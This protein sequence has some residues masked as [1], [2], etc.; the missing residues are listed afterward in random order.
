VVSVE[1]LHVYIED[2]LTS[3][4][5]CD[6]DHVSVEWESVSHETTREGILEMEVTTQLRV[7]NVCSSPP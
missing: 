4:S 5:V 1:A 7:V 3:L 2:T 6:G